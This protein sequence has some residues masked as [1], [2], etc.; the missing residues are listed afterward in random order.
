MRLGSTSIKSIID[1]GSRRTRYTIDNRLF[2]LNIIEDIDMGPD[3]C[4]LKNRNPISTRHRVCL[5]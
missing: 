1:E 2:R 3:C 5:H 4:P